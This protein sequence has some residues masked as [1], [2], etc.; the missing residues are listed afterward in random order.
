MGNSQERARQKHIIASKI[1]I[2]PQYQFFLH[3]AAM[4]FED[5]NY[6]Q[7]IEWAQ[8]AIEGEDTALY[9]YKILGL[10]FMHTGQFQEAKDALK[11][12]LEQEPLDTECGEAFNYCTAMIEGNPHSS[13]GSSMTPKPH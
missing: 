4:E 13:S 8:Q 2:N 11:F 12:F 3:L 5:G 10:A 7:A 1:K 9:T 6:N